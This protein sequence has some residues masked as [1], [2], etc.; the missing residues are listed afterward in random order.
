VRVFFPKEEEEEKKV[1]RER[2]E[3]KR[4]P[5]KIEN[6]ILLRVSLQGL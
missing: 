3:Q 6:S 1:K 2:K 5:K 4:Q